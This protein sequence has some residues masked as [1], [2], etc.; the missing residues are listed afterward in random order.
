MQN[1]NRR[2]RDQFVK[3]VE[4]ALGSVKNKNIAVLGL[5]FKPNTDDM[6]EAPS[7]DIINAL[8]ERGALIKAYDPVAM[9]KAK[10]I[11]KNTIT[12][13]KNAYEPMDGADALVILTEWKEFLTLDFK[14]IKNLLNKSIIID[15]RNMFSS[16]KMASLGFKYY[17]IGRKT[18]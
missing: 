15:G 5:S 13:S 12:Y 18:K 1:I 7:V 11:F 10:E 17:S 8:L 14:K 2:Q 16:E 9:E 6:R 4:E 3:K